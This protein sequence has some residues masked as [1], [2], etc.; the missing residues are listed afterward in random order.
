MAP[1]DE[2][3]ARVYAEGAVK[4]KT[5]RLMALCAAV[6]QG[7]TGCILFQ[8]DQALGLGAGVEEIS[9][10]LAVAVA[11]GGSMASSHAA[12]AMALLEQKGLL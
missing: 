1:Y 8:A 5:K 6:T 3:S 10:T 9:E 2:L 7:C 12:E 4:A 11:L